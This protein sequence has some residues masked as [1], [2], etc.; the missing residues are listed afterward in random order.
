MEEEK[1]GVMSMS[2][3]EEKAEGEEGQEEE[4]QEQS[5]IKFIFKA[6]RDD[7]PATPYYDE[8]NPELY[9]A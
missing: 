2:E 9:T 1:A 4:E 5:D 3:G 6:E 8:G 7:V